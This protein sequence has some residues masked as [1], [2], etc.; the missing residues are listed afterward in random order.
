MINKVSN[1]RIFSYIIFVPN[2]VTVNIY[3]VNKSVGI[4]CVSQFGLNCYLKSRKTRKQLSRE[5]EPS[6]FRELVACPFASQTS[7]KMLCK[8]SIP[9]RTAQIQFAAIVCKLWR[10]KRGI[11]EKRIRDRTKNAERKKA[12]ITEALQKD[13]NYYKDIHITERT[14]RSNVQ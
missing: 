6:A 7:R 3:C 2:T 14:E 11:E 1:N 4:K 12:S 9:F 8:N 10:I 5:R 13:S